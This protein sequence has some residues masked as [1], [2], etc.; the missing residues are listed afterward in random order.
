M[1]EGE[2]NMMVWFAW[3]VVAQRRQRRA[4]ELN[5]DGGKNREEKL[6]H[7]ELGYI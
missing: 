2:A 3:L 1:R 6:T 4:A 7:G 5:G